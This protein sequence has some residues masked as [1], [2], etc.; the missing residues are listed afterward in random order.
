MLYFRQENG[1]QVGGDSSVIKGFTNSKQKERFQINVGGSNS[2]H[3]QAWT[4][5]K[6]LLSQNKD[7]QTNF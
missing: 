3:N 6:D 5:C 2:G 4:K 1:Q 7:I